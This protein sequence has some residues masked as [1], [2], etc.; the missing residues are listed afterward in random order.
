[1]LGHSIVQVVIWFLDRPAHINIIS[2]LDIRAWM[3]DALVPW[4]AQCSSKGRRGQVYM[5]KVNNLV[6]PARP[7]RL[8][9][10]KQEYNVE[11]PIKLCHCVTDSVIV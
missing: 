4:S 10:Q 7:R 9:D 5:Y 8:P 3:T 2:V 11:W 1:M 6:K